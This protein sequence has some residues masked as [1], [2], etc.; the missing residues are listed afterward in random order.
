MASPVGIAAAESSIREEGP[1]AGA[2]IQTSGS[3]G[4]TICSSPANR[5]VTFS[6]YAHASSRAGRIHA[7]HFFTALAF[8]SWVADT[9]A[10]DACAMVIAGDINALVGWDITLCSLP[11]TMAQAPSFHVLP[12]PTAQHW[13]GRSATVRAQKAKEAMASPRHAVSI[14]IAITGTVVH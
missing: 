1:M 3:W 12:I 9:G 2:L 5:T 6:S 4:L 11:A 13:A 14:P 10:H 7:V 8:V